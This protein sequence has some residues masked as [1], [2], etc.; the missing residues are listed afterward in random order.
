MTVKE[1]GQFCGLA[2]AMEVVGERWTLLIVRDLLLGPK[3]YTDL[4]NGLPNIPTNI[5]ATRLKQL[6]AHG[7]AVRRA[8]P[9][10]DRGVV[11]ELTDHGH[12]LQ[13]AVTALGRWGARTMTEPRPGEITT[14]ESRALSFHT[15]FR[16]EAAGEDTLD[17]EVRMADA[18]FRLSVDGPSLTVG[19]GPHPD[20]DLVIETRAGRPVLDLMRGTL[21]PAEALASGSL[22]IE[23]PAPLLT[24]FAEIFRL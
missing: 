4:R 17:Y 23:G 11:Y 6:E 24:R 16:P 19:H 21:T 15:A 3:R 10:P 7:V 2:R 20:P 1:Y 8:L 22:H 9:H 12:E 18:T 5:L 13:P 14:T